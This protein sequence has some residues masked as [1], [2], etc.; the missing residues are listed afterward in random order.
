ML[1]MGFRCLSLLLTTICW[2]TKVSQNTDKKIKAKIA[3]E[4]MDK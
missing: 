3:K 2:P 4:M 1:Y